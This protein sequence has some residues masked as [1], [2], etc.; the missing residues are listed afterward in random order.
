MRLASHAVV[1]GRLTSRAGR[2]PR[3]GRH[4]SG[5]GVGGRK[6]AAAGK[7]ARDESRSVLEGDAGASTS[8]R[9]TRPSF[10]GAK[11][12]DAGRCKY[13]ELVGGCQRLFFKN[14]RA[15]RTAA[16]RGTS[17]RE[18]HSTATFTRRIGGR[19]LKGPFPRT[20]M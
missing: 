8:G 2:P 12:V 3:S 11:Q 4:P 19:E 14:V 13:N 7:Y 10:L 1:V 20:G 16:G 18:V 9:N 15:P 17:T 5:A 6:A